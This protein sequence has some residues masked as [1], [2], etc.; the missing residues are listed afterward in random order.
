M[1]GWEGQV[2]KEKGKEIIHFVY[3]VFNFFSG[4]SGG[5]GSHESKCGHM[6]QFLMIGLLHDSWIYLNN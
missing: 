2:K 5:S 1:V 4:L 3:M 6:A